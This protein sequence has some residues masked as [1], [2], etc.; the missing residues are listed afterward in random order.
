[1]AF[2]MTMSE[3]YQDRKFLLP[4][5]FAVEI[6]PALLLNSKKG[7]VQLKKYMERSIAN[8]FRV[9][10]GT[11]VDT[12][13]SSTARKLGLGFRISVINKGDLTSDLTQ[14]KKIS[15]LLERFRRNVRLVSMV[16]FA[17][18][19]NIDRTKVDWDTI[20]EKPAFKKE[21]DEYLADENES[22]Q[23][24]FLTSL[25]KLKEDYKKENWNADKLDIAIAILSTSADSL[26]KNIRFNCADLWLAWSIKSGKNSLLM[27][28]LNAKIDKN[29]A[30]TANDSESSSYSN[31]SIPARFLIG[32]NRVKGFAEA[33]YSYEGEFNY[34]K[35]F[36]HLGVE[37]NIVDGVWLNLTGGFDENTSLN[38]SKFIANFNLKLT[39]PENFR[40]F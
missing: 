8:S 13:L 2:A 34:H 16:K 31:I 20:F 17:D 36:F 21:F 6:S 28:G 24:I 9:S 4:K 14:L 27:L 23:K 19:K 39:L 15:D 29:L 5:A 40:L 22:S 7:P 11:S 25:K 32:T 26:F 37:V 30:D 33:Q 18:L 35:F 12:L 10:L 1:M 3:L 38:I